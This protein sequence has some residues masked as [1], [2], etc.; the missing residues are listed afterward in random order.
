MARGAHPDL[1]FTTSQGFGELVKGGAAEGWVAG[2]GDVAAL[3]VVA[4][5]L[6]TITA[7]RRPELAAKLPFGSLGVALAYFAAAV[8]VEVH[9]LGNLGGG[10]TG[11]PVTPHASWAYGFYIGV[12][13]GAIAGLSGLALRRNELGR[14]GAA[15]DAVSGVFGIALLISFLLPWIGQGDIFSRPGIDDAAATLA[16]VVLIFGAP[17]VRSEDGRRW[18]LPLVAGIAILT[19]GA[20]SATPFSTVSRYGTWIGVGSVVLLLAVEAARG[21]PLRLPALP[22]GSA[23]LELGAA[24]LLIVALFLPWQEISIPHHSWGTHGWYVVAGAAVGGLCLLLLAR[25]FLP[26]VENYALDTAV[27]I[28]VFASMLGTVFRQGGPF[29]RLGYGAYVGLTAAGVLLVTPLLRFRP[30]PV[31]RTRALAR[32]VP[33]AASVLCVAAI[34]V[35]MWF[36][37]PQDWTFQATALYYGWFSAAGVLLALYLVR[38][39]S[40]RVSGTGRAGY[41][42]TLV[43]LALLALAALDLIRFRG[44][45]V[46]WGR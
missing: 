46:V 16:A 14:P 32:A 27:A 18:R 25:A 19:A 7:L 33:L 45:D 26:A 35:P 4:I 22:R 2:A 41:Q 12:A 9:A 1:P 3:L 42:L 28:A 43:P 20:A 17:R 11:H 6:G 13:S 5:A 37:L 29:L 31:D 8:A 23:A 34:V 44:G 36:V 40:V 15:V 10:F 39:W 30:G 24:S 38:L 21:W